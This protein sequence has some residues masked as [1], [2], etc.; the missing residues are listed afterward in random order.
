M[1][2]SPVPRTNN[3]DDKILLGIVMYASVTLV[4][5]SYISI[6]TDCDLLVG[7]ELVNTDETTHKK[8]DEEAAAFFL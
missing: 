4:A 5:T 7:L 2:G 1:V 8:Q 6:C 3:L